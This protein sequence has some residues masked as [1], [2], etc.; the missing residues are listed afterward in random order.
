MKRKILCLVL[1]V[2]LL[3]G[4]MIFHA[5]AV[6]DMTVS[7]DGAAFIR[8][9]M[10]NELSANQLAAAES[11]V[12]A[13]A[14]RYDLQLRQT[15]FDALVDFVMA[16][17]SYV[18][19]SGYQCETVIG[20]GSYTDLEV[21]NAFCAWVKNGASFD[22]SR[23]TRRLREIKLFLYDDYTGTQCVPTVRYLIFNGNGGT[24]EDNT[25]LCYTLDAAY[26]TLPTATRS[27]K[28]FAGWYTASSGGAHICNSDT[29][30]QNHT[31]YAHWS[32]EAVDSPNEK[33]DGDTPSDLTPPE[34]KTTEAGVQFIKD[35]EGF[36]KYAVWDYSQY[37]IGYGSRCE[38]GEF[39]DGIT[40]EEADYR[41]RVMLADFEKVVDAVLEKGTVEH[42]PQ[43]Y[44]AIMSF[45]YNLGRQWMKEDNQI[46]Q[47]ILYGGYENEMEFVNAIGKWIN[48]GGTPLD[49]LARRRMSEANLYLNGEYAKTTGRYMRLT[50]NAMSG[51]AEYNYAYYRTGEALG[52]LPNATRAGYQLVGW[53]DKVAGG[54]QYTE[55]T[56]AP[57]YAN[58]TVYAHWEESDEPTEE[59]TE[60]GVEPTESDEPTQKPSE[61]VTVEPTE[62]STEPGV[63]PT[64][65]PTEPPHEDF[66]DVSPNSWYYTPVMTAVNRGLFSGISE[67]EFS[68]DTTMTRAMLVT[69]L[70]RMDG[71]PEP[72]S[73]APFTDVPRNMWFSKAVDWA[74]EKGVVNGI[75][76][77]EFGLEL[78]VTR[79][80][81][82][83]MLCRYAAA[84]GYDV[85]ARAELTAFAD[86]DRVSDYA[87]DALQWAVAWGILNGYDGKM[88][89]AGEA[90][91]AQCAKMLTV[92][93]DRC[94][95][96]SQPQ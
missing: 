93:L 73:V 35:H 16:Y 56:T 38:A 5:A 39:P 40:E 43:Q 46:Y 91:R 23:L 89:P 63:E 96:Q 19:T 6:E 53:F 81:L 13:F 82:T 42:T 34:L 51:E 1:A 36:L 37:S 85:S 8:E 20:S 90:T 27:G 54:T 79:E 70:Y 92:F 58:Y 31:V 41:L 24:L 30:T 4:T 77:T 95:E 49:G 67:T 45:T 87:K 25:V 9:M 21:A 2:S 83:T 65:A 72:T 74:Y 84:C 17:G 22:Q 18:L 64:E 10:A 55:D 12:N 47:F 71:S 59:P 62:E 48:A 28:Y 57:G 68:P 14:R 69:V 26:G 76:A 33:Q 88:L 60:P 86:A 11:T 75:S 32:D 15:Q 66:G 7:E 80:Q 78:S 50:F 29:V 44:D 3:A 61:S 94:A 52:A